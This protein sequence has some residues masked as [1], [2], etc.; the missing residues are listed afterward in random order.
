MRKLVP[1]IVL[2]IVA[3]LLDQWIKHLVETG[4]SLQQPVELLPFL[5]LYRTYNTGIA[6][7]MLSSLGDTGLIVVALVV[8]AFVLYLAVRTAPGQ[9]L[10]RIGFALIVGGAL[11]NLI[12]RAVYGHVIDYILFHTPVWSFAVFNL[13]D[14]FITLGAI[15][16]IF[17]EFIAWR[18]ESRPSED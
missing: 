17:D 16:V 18:R 8:V 2:A 12:D 15:L 3:V 13:A 7:S 11:G 5:A 9:V 4:L 14:A 6:F 10:S 1:Y